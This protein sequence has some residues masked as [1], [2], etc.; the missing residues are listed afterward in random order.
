MGVTSVSPTGV[1]AIQGQAPCLMVHKAK[2]N[3]GHTVGSN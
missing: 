2:E 1:W 3:D